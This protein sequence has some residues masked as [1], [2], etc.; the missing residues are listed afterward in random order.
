VLAEPRVLD[1]GVRGDEVEQHAQ[2]SRVRL[3]DEAV[4]I[5]EAPEN[6]VDGRVVG[7]VVAEVGER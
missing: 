4:E 2:A 7:D 5:L 3:A 6:G 1:R